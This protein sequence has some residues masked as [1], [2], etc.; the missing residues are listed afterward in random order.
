[1]DVN[2]AI[3][4]F[5]LGLDKIDSFNSA[6]LLPEEIS[7]YLSDA[8]EEFI[9]QRAY[10][11]NTKR[12]GVE[13]SQKRVKDLQSL[14]QNDHANLFL[15]FDVIN[16]KPNGRFVP[17]PH[18]YRHAINEEA[19]IEITDCNNVVQTERVPIVPLTHDK[20]NRV[21]ANPFSQPSN[22]KVYRLPYGRINGTEYFEIIV[23]PYQKLID[24][25]L[26]Y[27]KNPRKIDQAQILN[28]LGLHDTDIMDLTDESYR[29]IIR[30]AV[31][32]A[33]GDIESTRV[34]E[35]IQRNQE[36]E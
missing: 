34:Q 35:S 27:I 24:Y 17:L 26:R 8:Q 13:E 18:D 16:N 14:T 3:Q 20:Y 23:A 30:I 2:T 25:Q 36:I 28:P 1:M 15:P 21:M 4:Q 9:E 10:G 31:R 29:E 19:I 11:N 32:N 12:L 6:N 22:N 33:L 7:V 5:K